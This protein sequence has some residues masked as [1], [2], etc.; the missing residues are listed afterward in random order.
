MS[1]TFVWR[2]TSG[3]LGVVLEKVEWLKLGPALVR[4]AVHAIQEGRDPRLVEF[5]RRCSKG[6]QERRGVHPD[7]VRLGMG[8]T[9]MPNGV[10]A[11]TKSSRETPPRRV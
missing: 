11:L 6:R 2:G 5:G 7:L 10:T 3:V 1:S 9:G 8:P 4:E